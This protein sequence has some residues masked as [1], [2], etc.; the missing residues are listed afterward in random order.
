[1]DELASPA[2]SCPQFTRHVVDP[3][4]NPSTVRCVFTGFVRRHALNSPSSW[5]PFQ[6]AL[7]VK[8]QLVKQGI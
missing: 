2:K 1:M 6:V 7:A 8:N 4:A 3:H 5:F